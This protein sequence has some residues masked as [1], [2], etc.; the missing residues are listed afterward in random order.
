MMNLN[1]GKKYTSYLYF[2]LTNSIKSDI[3]VY[4]KIEFKI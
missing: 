2:L 4:V 3:I 1:K